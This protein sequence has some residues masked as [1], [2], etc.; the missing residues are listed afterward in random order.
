MTAI[1][2]ALFAAAHIAAQEPETTPEPT[3]TPSPASTPRK[4]P[5]RFVPP[6]LEGRISLGIYDSQGA[7]VRILHRE[8]VIDAFEIGPDALATT[9]DGR[10]E[11]DQD[12]PPGRYRAHGFVVG[13]VKIESLG[14]TTDAPPPAD[15]KITLKLVPNELAPGKKLTADITAGFDQHASYLQTADGLPLLTVNEALDIQSVALAQRDDKSLDLYQ[16][17]GGTTLRFHII[18]VE[19]MMAFDC[20]DFDLK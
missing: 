9:W 12:L 15:A 16:Q 3:P 11:A 8:A 17:S 6:P 4:V 1:I 5:I 19:K 13:K 20:G 14:T 18:G 2:I 7:L 10:D